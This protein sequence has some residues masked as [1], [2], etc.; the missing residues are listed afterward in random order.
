MAK[1]IFFGSFLYLPLHLI[2]GFINL[3]NGNNSFETFFYQTLILTSVLS[4]SFLFTKIHNL[5][6]EFKSFKYHY[7]S[8]IDRDKK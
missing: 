8:F 4:I 6:E 5:N 3:G 2:F 1:L 7:Y